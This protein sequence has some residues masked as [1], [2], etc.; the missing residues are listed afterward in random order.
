MSLVSISKNYCVNNDN[1]KC[2][3]SNMPCRLSRGIP[4]PYFHD[5]VWPMFDPAYKYSR[6]HHV[7][8]HNYKEFQAVYKQGTA[9]PPRRCEC[10][11]PLRPRDRYCS[12]CR[13]KR[14]RETYRKNKAKKQVRFPQLTAF[15][16]LQ[17]LV[18]Q[19][20]NFGH[21]HEMSHDTE[22]SVCVG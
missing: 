15:E 3:A 22:L 21:P 13:H 8:E 19:Q 1:G 17:P 9:V 6:D 2:I 5:A 7:Y 4:C 10:G 16:P 20:L 14:R 11:Q 12:E 18:S